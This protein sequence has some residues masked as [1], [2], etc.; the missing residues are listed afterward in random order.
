[1]LNLTATHTH[2]VQNYC[3]SRN[4]L[5]SEKDS[6]ACC[7]LSASL[8]VPG[9]IL[10]SSHADQFHFCFLLIFSQCITIHTC[11]NEPLLHPCSVW[12]MLQWHPWKLLIFFF[13]IIAC[14]SGDGAIK[15][16]VIM[17][18]TAGY[19]TGGIGRKY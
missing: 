1:M 8:G 18:F 9:V 2:T 3:H 17:T 10:K 13:Q 5:T 7:D 6:L 11:R 12:K 15:R 14:I 19:Y 4:Y 16:L